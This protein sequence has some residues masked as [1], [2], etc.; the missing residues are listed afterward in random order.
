MLATQQPVLRRFWY[1]VMP[2]EQLDDG[3]KPFRLMNEELVL[4]LDSEGK[5]HAAEDRCAHRTA[6]LSL[7]WVEGDNI[8]CPYHGWTYDGG[9]GCVRIP[10]TPDRPAGRAKVRAFNAEARY[11][12]VWV[13]L[14]DPLTDIPHMPEADE[15]G[16]RVI[17]QFYEVWRTAGLRLM[18]NSFDNAH[19]SFVHRESFGQFDKPI[20][21]KLNIVEEDF[22][23]RFETV[24]PV[25]NPPLQ[26]KLLKMDSDTTERHMTSNWFMPF[27][28]KLNIRYPNG[29]VHAI[30]TYATPIDDEHSMICQWAY[31]SDSEADAPAEQI[32]AFDRQ[33][34]EE[35]KRVLESTE[36]DAPLDTASGEERHM[37]SDQPGMVMRKMLLALLARFG[38]E[39][40]RISGARIPMKEKAS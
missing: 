21:A 16:Y 39:E 32:I 33:V 28:R 2:L 19:F 10:Q 17:H 14:G 13:C 31:R 30:I 6:R 20:P 18:E 7:G 9:G 4:W 38:E 12:Y 1:P 29:L 37:P 40:A 5:P 34:T 27:G 23:F 15:P 35:D 22:G 24:A 26:K 25:N 8:V 36:Y 3:P 11:G